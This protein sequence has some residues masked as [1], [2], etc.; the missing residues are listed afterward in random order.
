MCSSQGQDFGVRGGGS[1][2]VTEYVKYK[3]ITTLLFARVN[4]DQCVLASLQDA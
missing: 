3:V 1:T 4:T 2:L